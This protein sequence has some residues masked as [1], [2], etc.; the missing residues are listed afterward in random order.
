MESADG[1]EGGVGGSVA[2][3]PEFRGA[4]VVVHEDPV[5]A[6]RDAGAGLGVPHMGPDKVVAGA[7]R[8]VRPGVEDEDIVHLSVTVVVVG[9]EID[10]GAKG[11]AGVDDHLGR[12]FVLAVLVV[13]AVIGMVMGKGDRLGDVEP[14]GVAVFPLVLEIGKGRFGAGAVDEILEIGPGMDEFEVLELGQDDEAVTDAAVLPGT[15]A[16]ELLLPERHR[17]PDP[18][19]P[20]LADQLVGNVP[21]GGDDLAGRVRVAGMLA[22]VQ[23][24]S[25]KV[26]AGVAPPSFRVL[27]EGAAVGGQ[28]QMAVFVAGQVGLDD[29]PVRLPEVQQ[30]LPG[31][32]GQEGRRQAEA[33]IEYQRQASQTGRFRSHTYTNDGIFSR[34][35]KPICKKPASLK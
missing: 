8:F 7:F 27:D 13:G 33:D 4:G 1:G 20:P 12:L 19:V 30:P 15:G 22:G 32:R 9:G 34:I 2:V 14:E 17:P 5:P 31:G 16:D 25:V 18:G 35:R 23:P 28:D 11:G 29:R 6:V 24:V 26:I 21:A 10:L 3:Q